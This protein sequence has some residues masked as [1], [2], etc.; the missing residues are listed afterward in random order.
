METQHTSGIGALEHDGLD[1]SMAWRLLAAAIGHAK[2][3]PRLS[4][5]ASDWSPLSRPLAS[6]VEQMRATAKGG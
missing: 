5:I 2:N 4:W 3:D 1:I 6:E